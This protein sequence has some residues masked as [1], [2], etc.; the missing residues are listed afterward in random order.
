MMN[1]RLD[2]LSTTCNRTEEWGVVG[3]Q[4]IPPHIHMI[5]DNW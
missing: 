4:K 2:R 3:K 5:A 1:D